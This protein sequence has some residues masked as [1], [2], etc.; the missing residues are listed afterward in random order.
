MLDPLRLSLEGEMLDPLQSHWKV[1]CW[2]YY[3]LS[4]EGE[5]LGPW[6]PGGY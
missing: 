3:S 1:K 2:I 4:L 6:G 5:M